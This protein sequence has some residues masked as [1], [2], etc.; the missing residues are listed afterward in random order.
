M[1]VAKV[2]G[3]VS[4][5]G[6]QVREIAGAEGAEA[7]PVGTTFLLGVA[8]RGPVGVVVDLDGAAH[9]DQLYGR[10]GG[11]GGTVSLGIHVP[12]W[13][14]AAKLP[15]GRTGGKLW[16]LRVAADDA[17][18]GKIP[19][20][21][22]HAPRSLIEKSPCSAYY[23]PAWTI[24]AGTP[25][26]ATG[27]SWRRLITVASVS[28][29]F[30][31]GAGTFASGLLGQPSGRFAGGYL[32]FPAIDSEWRSRILSYDPTTGNMDLDIDAT[33]AIVATA[34]TGRAVVTLDNYNEWESAAEGVRVE[35]ADG[36]D[37]TTFA[38]TATTDPGAYVDTWGGLSIAEGASDWRF[39]LDQ[40]RQWTIAAPSAPARS[41]LVTDPLS[42]PCN[43]AEIPIRVVGRRVYL[44]T[45]R[46]TRSP[47]KANGAYVDT[48]YDWTH[49]A[50]PRALRLVATFSA[51]TAFTVEVQ[52]FAGNV[53]A[54]GADLPAGTLG[55]AWS[56]G[57][58][59]IPGFTL[60]AGTTA[61]SAADTVEITY[62]PIP[63]D[64]TAR[65]GRLYL[66]AG[67]TEGDTR[68]FYFATA[69]G[70]DWIEVSDSGIGGLVTVPL[71]P[72]QAGTEAGPYD[73][74]AGSLTFIYT[75]PGGGSALTLTSTL[76]GAAET[77]AAIVADLNAQEL[78]RATVAADKLIEFAVGADGKPTWT[79]L[80]NL[81][82]E[83]SYTVG[84]G[85]LN[86]ILGFTAG[87]VVGT[88]GK[89]VRLQVAQDLGG[90]HN[91]TDLPDGGDYGPFVEA[92]A[93]GGA[94]RVIEEANTGLIT[95]GA[96]EFPVAEIMVALAQAA[97][98]TGGDALVEVPPD[99]QATE[100]AAIAWF[101]AN[102]VGGS[103]EDHR[104]AVYPSQITFTPRTHPRTV[105]T[106]SAT[107]LVLGT[108]AKIAV[109]EGY[110]QAP[111]N[112]PRALLTPIAKGLPTGDRPLDAEL[113]TAHGGFNE[114]RKRG[115]SIAIMGDRIR[116]QT[117]QADGTKRTFLHWRRAIGH[118]VRVCRVALQP[119]VFG[120]TD[121]AGNARAKRLAR[122]AFEPYYRA[123]WFDDSGGPA[124]ENQV[125]I[126]C[127]FS[128][129]GSADRAAG[130]QNVAI[131]FRIVGT[132]ERVVVTMDP[133][134]TALASA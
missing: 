30:A 88:D 23:D 89:I 110:A 115:P 133:N 94:L 97:E 79:A 75:P 62:R 96:P 7:S 52:D 102:L 61:M 20:W 113:L 10:T 2:Y 103:W 108:L 17:A 104:W 16:L 50:A 125:A 127:D 82:S 34:G 13:F 77:A 64:F 84:A 118:L 49:P 117:V 91:G 116:T 56:S 67:P 31:S 99:N 29:A 6:V 124:F 42:R 19:V 43:H 40:E 36:G 85:T 35:F 1:A 80:Q 22:R 71:A 59:W 101:D 44:Q 92:L 130:N 37:D 111:A 63:E 12:L 123:G 33:A 78:A 58:D 132:A 119:Q 100:R 32:S 76:D 57:V 45:V 106:I 4:G 21:T 65:K 38:L 72:T 112:A 121:A 26:L 11:G 70:A 128:N 55:T 25:G 120:K 87:A 8:N 95:Y 73:L 48:R 126:V 83:A 129:N 68:A 3:P 114:L 27:K 47:A 74:S 14:Q 69:H 41:L 46:W 28:T 24:A 109:Q 131:S 53:L 18:A 122:L 9:G 93:A 54:A 86:A 81:G 107:G 51:A 98:R 105:F 90:G 66:A 60:R 15:S 134:G 39:V 5:P